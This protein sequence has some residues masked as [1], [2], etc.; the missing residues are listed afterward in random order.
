M[1]I[2]IDTLDEPEAQQYGIDI[3]SDVLHGPILTELTEFD[4]PGLPEAG[5]LFAT[6][7]PTKTGFSVKVRRRR[8]EDDA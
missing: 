7:V 4:H 1:R 5:E 8:Q 2:I 6:A 3:A